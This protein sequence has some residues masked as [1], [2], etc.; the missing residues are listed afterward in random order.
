[1]ASRMTALPLFGRASLRNQRLVESDRI[2]A[3]ADQRQSNLAG[4]GWEGTE[5]RLEF[6]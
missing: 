6:V 1:M 5:A 4:T 3:E 2:E